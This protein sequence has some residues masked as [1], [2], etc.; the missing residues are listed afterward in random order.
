MATIYIK[1]SDGR[2]QYGVPVDDT[3]MATE[4]ALEVL[5]VAPSIMIT[6]ERDYSIFESTNGEI[7]FPTDIDFDNIFDIEEPDFHEEFL[8]AE[9]V[10][11][12]EYLIDMVNDAET[13][14]VESVQYQL[15]LLSL[16]ARLHINLLDEG[17]PLLT[18]PHA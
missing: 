2:Y 15:L 4:L 11:D 12:L 14:S 5:S 1:H 7:I 3:L 13:G 6:N 17:S 18:L 9:T 8:D 10:E 16:A